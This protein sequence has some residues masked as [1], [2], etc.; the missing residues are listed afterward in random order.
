GFFLHHGE[1][2]DTVIE[3]FTIM[4]GYLIGDTGGSGI[5]GGGGGAGI[6]TR[7]GSPTIR[8]CELRDNVS[9]T[10]GNPFI[11]D[12]RGGGVL[13][14][15]G[16]NVSLDGCTIANNYSGR[17]GGG[18]N[19]GVGSS[20]VVIRNCLI[21]NNTSAGGFGGGGMSNSFSQTSIVHTSIVGNSA[22]TSFGGGVRNEQG[23]LHLSNCILAANEGIVG[24]QILVQGPIVIIEYC[25]VEGGLA[26]IYGFSNPVIV[27]GPGNIDADPLFVDPDDGD[28]HL[29]PG[30]PCIDA[31]N[32]LAVPGGVE[33]DLDGFARFADDLATP[34]TGNPA[35]GVGVVDMGA[36]E[37]GGDDCNNNGIPDVQDVADGATDCDGNNVP[38]EC[39]PDCDENDQADACEDIGEDCDGNGRM[40]ECDT[41]CN[42]NGQPDACD[43]ADGT[44]EDCNFNLVP[45][46]CEVNL[47]IIEHPQDQQ[48]QPG[49][50][51]IFSVAADIFL[52]AYQWRKDGVELENTDR[53]IGTNSQTLF[54]IDIIPEDAGQYDCVVTDQATG[55]FA[56]SDPAT[57]TVHGPC[58]ADFD[59]N[60]AVGPF[61]LA[62]LLGNWGPNPNHPADLNDDDIIDAPDLALLL[63]AWGPCE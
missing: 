4:N 63:G 56:A 46:E 31:A 55:C 20:G 37:F 41:D 45:D 9:A 8:N 39:Q 7:D 17:G 3:G 38:D 53:I 11:E 5:N 6:Y 36:Y 62:I 29:L 50:M 32:N 27:W 59:G 10:L 34:D 19:V 60:G 26:D 52:P 49:E 22:E 30:S 28:F 18:I 14:D 21:I 35:W 15:G 43:L 51:A 23:E 47:P 61:D 58:P 48:V 33:S 16:S 57:L 13:I 24:P 12:G 2:R 42:A 40:D 44:S 25:N 54:I 1:T